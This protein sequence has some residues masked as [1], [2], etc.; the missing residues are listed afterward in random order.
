MAY[1]MIPA[2]ITPIKRNDSIDSQENIYEDLLNTSSRHTYYRE[3][4]L[5][6]QGVKGGSDEVD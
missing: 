2:A 4:G 1:Q 6:L 5:C 3:T